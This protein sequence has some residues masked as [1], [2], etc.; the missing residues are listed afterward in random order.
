MSDRV[1]THL[2]RACSWHCNGIWQVGH[3][4]AG[5]VPGLCSL[6]T[7]ACQRLPCTCRMAGELASLM[8]RLSVRVAR[9][10]AAEEQARD[11][12][13]KVRC[14]CCCLQSRGGQHVMFL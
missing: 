6:K 14:R 9:Y 12:R 13:A 11:A 4:V 3:A 10:E 7:G 8:M 1:F 2:R 5:T